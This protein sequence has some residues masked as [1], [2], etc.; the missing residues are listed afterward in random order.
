MPLK[1]TVQKPSQMVHDLL[2]KLKLQVFT[3]TGKSVGTVDMN[4]DINITKQKIHYLPI[5]GSDNKI[6]QVNSATDFEARV[7]TPSK[8]IVSECERVVHETM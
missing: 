2:T 8:D 1:L 6:L 4:L 7:K 5:V 3:G